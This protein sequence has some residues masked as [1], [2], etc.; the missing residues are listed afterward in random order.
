MIFK[1]NQSIALGD[2]VSSLQKGITITGDIAMN[3]SL[4]IDCKVEGGIAGK[5]DDAAGNLVIGSKA[6]VTG[7]VVAANIEVY[8]SVTGNITCRSLTIHSKA[9]VKGN[10]FY[11]MIEMKPEAVV[12]GEIHNRTK[13][14]TNANNSSN[15]KK[16]N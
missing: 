4:Y 9:H 10:I 11:H 1:K 2:N 13:T 16:L 5:Q 14:I 12:E 6:I 8:G 7:D 3:G 15:N